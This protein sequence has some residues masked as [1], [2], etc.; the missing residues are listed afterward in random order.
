MACILD[1]A[2]ACVDFTVIALIVYAHKRLPA[3]FNKT[4]TQ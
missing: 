1:L 2:N 4:A 3:H